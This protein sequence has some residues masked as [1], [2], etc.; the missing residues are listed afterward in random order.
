MLIAAYAFLKIASQTDLVFVRHG[1]TFANATGRY[2]SKTLNEFSDKGKSEV[3]ALTGRLL[4][5]P[6]FD[7]ILV[8]PSPRAL[9]TIAPYLKATHQKATVWPLLY[10][11]CTGHRPKNAAATHF[12]FGATIRIASDIAMLFTV[13]PGHDRYPNS[14]DYNSGLAQVEA[15]LAEYKLRFAGGRVLMVGHSGHGGQFLHALTGRWRKIENCKEV[16]V[17]TKE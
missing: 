2:N 6:K 9:R 12:S 7:R 4:R 11:C 5:Q 14:P 13:E 17:S 15:S 8:S 1:E 10:E 3:E 16:Q